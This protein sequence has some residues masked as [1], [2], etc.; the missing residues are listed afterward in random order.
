MN[1]RQLLTSAGAATLAGKLG[2]AA[3]AIA[4]SDASAQLD[5]LFGAF[6]SENLDLQPE[7]ATSLG[8]DGG[9]RAWEKS[10]LADRSPEGAKAQNDLAA[11]QLRRLEA[12]DAGALPPADALNRDVVLYGMRQQ[13]ENARRFKYAGG[14]AGSPYALNQFQGSAYHDLPDFL[15]SQHQI[16]ATA[17]AE[18][19]LARLE[20]FP[21]AMDQEVQSVRLDQS[22]GVIPP[23]FVLDRTLILLKGLRATPAEKS[24]LVTSLVRRAREKGIDGDWGGRATKLYVD[25]VIPAFDRQIALA[26]DLR[27]LARHDAGVWRLPDGDAYYTASVAFWTTTQLTGDEIHRTGLDVVAQL[28]ARVDAAMKAQGLTQGTVGERFR[29]MYDEPKYRYPNTDEGKAKLLAD[30]NLKVA[31][32]QARLPDY[33]GV[34]PKAKVEIKR[35]PP[36]TESGAPGGYYQP[37]A[38]DGSRPGAY[39]I[40]LRDTAEV[41]SW[42]LSTLTYHESIP[43]HHLQLSIAEEA[44]LPL[45]RKLSFYS[46][47]IEGWALYAEQLAEE[48]GMYEGHPMGHIGYLHDALFRGVRLVVDSGL[49]AKRWSREKAI[50]YYV[51]TLGDKDASATTEVERYCVTPGQA[52]GYML[53]KLTSGCASAPAPGP[54]SAGGS[55]STNFTTPP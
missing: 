29:A 17:D 46:A 32:V 15:D 18:A 55:T 24:V 47:Y 9:P 33:F 7:F 1:R 23:D 42:T 25:K 12:F 35:I 30:L 6:V 43:G 8:M 54:R 20:A 39:Y 53:G 40:N 37:G 2:F 4:A 19:Y 27:S 41:P 3:P 52:C 38:L 26:Q 51:E 14:G 16:A 36:Y 48:M 50:A 13:V 21:V 5:A 11:G 34:R 10:K 28:S 44:P 31:A 22:L 45:I 49:H